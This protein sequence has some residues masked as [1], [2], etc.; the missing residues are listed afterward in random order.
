MYT[1]AFVNT[2]QSS[3]W[4]L[5]PAVRAKVPKVVSTVAMAEITK[6]N[7]QMMAVY[8]P[9]VNDLRKAV[10]QRNIDKRPAV[11]P[12]TILLYKVVVMRCNS[13]VEKSIPGRLQLRLP[14]V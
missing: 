7:A 2:A 9:F 4:V 6:A 11:V 12:I 10:K 5:L 8:R 1:T 13:D 14:R 3:I